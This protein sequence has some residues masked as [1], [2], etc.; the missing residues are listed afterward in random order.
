MTEAHMTLHRIIAAAESARSARGYRESLKKPDLGWVLDLIN[1]RVPAPLGAR[2]H[3]LGLELPQLSKY[4]V[5]K[6][7]MCYCVVY[8]SEHC[9]MLSRT[10]ALF[11]HQW[12][13]VFVSCFVFLPCWPICF[14]INRTYLH[15]DPEPCFSW[16]CLARTVTI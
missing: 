4:W 3:V 7:C 12:C 6:N 14:S 11:C 15:L 8:C 5:D 1:A 10:P 9:S 16:V 2:F 13:P